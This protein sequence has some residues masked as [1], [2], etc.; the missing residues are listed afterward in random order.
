[1]QQI[2]SDPQNIIDRLCLRLENDELPE[3]I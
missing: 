3:I 1:M 2:A